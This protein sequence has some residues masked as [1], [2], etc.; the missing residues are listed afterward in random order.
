MRVVD[1]SQMT[2]KTYVDAKYTAKKRHKDAI[3]VTK[4]TL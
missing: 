1:V 4:A 2:Y 3:A